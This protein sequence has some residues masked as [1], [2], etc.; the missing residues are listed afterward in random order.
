MDKNKTAAAELRR[1]EKNLEVSGLKFAKDDVV[2]EV[3]KIVDHIKKT[4]KELEIGDLEY[5]GSIYQNLKVNETDEFDFDIPI[6]AFETDHV[7]PG[8]TKGNRIFKTNL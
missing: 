5:T 8:P 3:L 7:Q 6:K 1:Y 2:P 4:S